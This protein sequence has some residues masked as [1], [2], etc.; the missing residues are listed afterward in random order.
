V[1]VYR[2]E[3]STSQ[4][5]CTNSVSFEVK[6]GWNDI[7]SLALSYFWCCKYIHVCIS[8]LAYHLCTVKNLMN[9]MNLEW[10]KTTICSYA[11]SR[12][13]VTPLK[14]HLLKC[15]WMNLVCLIA[16]SKEPY[17]W[18]FT[19]LLSLKLIHVYRKFIFWTSL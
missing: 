1:V 15:D 8:A 17:V 6:D 11:T 12:A 7:L 3:S 5:K 9:S 18:N 14:K 19:F 16:S 4:G 13:N 10:K 2:G